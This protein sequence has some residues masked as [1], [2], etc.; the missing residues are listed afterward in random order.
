MTELECRVGLH[1]MAVGDFL[2]YIWKMNKK[3]VVQNGGKA[4][5]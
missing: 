5:H 1:P 2:E 4:C 3:M